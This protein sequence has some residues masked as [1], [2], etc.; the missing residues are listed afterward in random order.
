MR[1]VRTRLELIAELVDVAEFYD[2]NGELDASC[3]T[4]AIF[5][6]LGALATTIA[7]DELYAIHSPPTTPRS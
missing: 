1:G 7:V 5:L 3:A 4:R 6:T 2:D